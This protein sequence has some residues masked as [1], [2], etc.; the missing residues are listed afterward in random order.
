MA[1]SNNIPA[2]DVEYYAPTR[3]LRLFFS[4]ILDICGALATS[5][6]VDRYRSYVGV[7]HKEYVL[8]R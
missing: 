7:H 3:Q 1:N 5:S 6:M 8:A 2:S 4:C